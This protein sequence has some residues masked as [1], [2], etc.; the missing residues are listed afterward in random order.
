MLD[1]ARVVQLSGQPTVLVTPAVTDPG[2]RQIRHT[3]ADIL[4]R[5]L[6]KEM[7]QTELIE[8]IE[9]SSFDGEEDR[10]SPCYIGLA[11]N[12]DLDSWLQHS[13]TL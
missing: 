12:C 8:L 3:R 10:Q 11:P 9:L 13:Q 1:L 7:D 4:L 6:S 2:W 5:D